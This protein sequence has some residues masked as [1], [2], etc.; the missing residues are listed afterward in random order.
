MSRGSGVEIRNRNAADIDGWSD[1]LS[2]RKSGRIL[3]VVPVPV[4]ARRIA[5]YTEGRISGKIC[6]QVFSRGQKLPTSRLKQTLAVAL[7]FTEGK[8]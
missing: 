7:I 1:T 3:V 8:K 5:D 2:A 4:L 6:N